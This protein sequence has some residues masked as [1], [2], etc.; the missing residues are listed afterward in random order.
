MIQ[1]AIILAGGIGSRLDFKKP[2]GFLNIYGRSLISYSI[3]NLL[4]RGILPHIGTG[5][6]SQFYELLGY[7]TFKNELYEKTGSLWTLREMKKIKGDILI[8]ESDLLYEPSLLQSVIDCPSPNVV[9]VANGPQKDAVFV[10][11]DDNG[12]L[13]KMSKDLNLLH[14]PIEGIVVGI[15][16]ISEVAFTN[17]LDKADKILESSPQQHYDYAFETI[18]DKF[19]ILKSEGVFTEIDDQE[20]LEYAI[21][22]VYPRLTF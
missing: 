20:Q 7:P 1:N 21:N 19:F 17:L 4:K 22:Y 11:I 5:Y 2:K 10:E 6:Q 14:N 3:E 18:E 13:K 15:T 9:L 12:Y 8:L 16:K